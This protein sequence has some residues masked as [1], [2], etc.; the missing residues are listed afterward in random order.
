[1]G[2]YMKHC[3]KVFLMKENPSPIFKGYEISHLYR[4]YGLNYS[5]SL[6]MAFW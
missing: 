2:D 1:L 4:F 5:Q 3:E 6:A